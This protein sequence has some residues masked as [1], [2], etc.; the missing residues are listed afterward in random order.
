MALRNLKVPNNRVLSSVEIHTVVRD[1]EN[2]EGIANVY[3]KTLLLSSMGQ[4]RKKVGKNERKKV[5]KKKER[6]KERNKKE[7]KKQ[8]ERNKK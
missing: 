1:L 5:I 8:K 2:V 6:K 4:K 7:R 3:C